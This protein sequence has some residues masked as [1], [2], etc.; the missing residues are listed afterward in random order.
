MVK[1]DRA[2]HTSGD[3]IS[4]ISELEAK[5]LKMSGAVR[6][7][8]YVLFGLGGVGR[9]LLRALLDASDKHQAQYGVGFVPR[10]DS[11]WN[12]MSFNHPTWRLGAYPGGCFA[13]FYEWRHGLLPADQRPPLAT[14]ASYCAA[15]PGGVDAYS[16]GYV[17]KQGV[18]TE[19]VGIGVEQ[20][21]DPN[22]LRRITLDMNGFKGSL[23]SKH[24]FVASHATATP[25][26]PN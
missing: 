15:V 24:G 18:M 5:R 13:P 26:A 11:M 10:T 17:E 14:P 19:Y 8:P 9:G 16:D 4:K 7:Q 2:A 6:T 3:L 12:D 23:I 21:I 25:G 20:T 22:G 1:I